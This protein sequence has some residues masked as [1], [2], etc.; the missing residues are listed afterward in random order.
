MCPLLKINPHPTVHHI[1][2]HLCCLFLSFSRKATGLLQDCQDCIE[3]ELEDVADAEPVVVLPKVEMSQL[4][5]IGNRD[6]LV[7]LLQ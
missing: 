4:V 2:L 7:I 3:V 1:L 6:R 5:L